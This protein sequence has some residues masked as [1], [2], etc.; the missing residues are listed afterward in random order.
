ME[1]HIKKS[2]FS[3]KSRFKEWKGAEGGHSLNFTLDFTV[4]CKQIRTK[5]WLY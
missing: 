2:Q 1:F 5:K 4:F 3:V